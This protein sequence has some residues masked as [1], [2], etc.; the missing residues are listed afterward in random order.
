MRYL[1]SLVMAA[2]VV[3]VAACAGSV[4]LPPVA[5]EEVELFFPGSIPNESYKVMSRIEE[6]APQSASDQEL[7]DKAKARAAEIGA[8]ALI[9]RSI[10]STAEGGIDLNLTQEIE[11]ILEAE[12]VYFPGRHPELEGS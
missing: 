5:P 2:L 8:D 12:A 10:R 7:I 9:I 11:K 6:R 4:T 3:V 1:P